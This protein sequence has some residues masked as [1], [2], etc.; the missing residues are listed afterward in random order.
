MLRTALGRSEWTRAAAEHGAR[1]ASLL[2]EGR[3]A[4]G[5][6]RA[7]HPIFNFL[8]SYYFVK[9]AADV[10]KKL[11]R[12]SPGALAWLRLGNIPDAEQDQTLSALRLERAP[13]D[14]PPPHDGRLQDSSSYCRVIVTQK[15]ADA[16]HFVQGVLQ[17]T[18]TNAPVLNCFGMH[19]WAMLYQE[20]DED[21]PFAAQFQSLPRRVAQQDINA[22]VRALKVNC[23]HFD[24]M[25]FFAK[26]AK[27]YSRHHDIDREQSFVSE[28]PACLHA[29]MDLLRHALKLGALIPGAMLANALELALEARALD[30]A[31]SPYDAT[32]FGLEPV[33]VETEV[34]KAEYK[35]RQ[36][37]LAQRA[38]PLRR[39]MLDYTRAVIDARVDPYASKEAASGAHA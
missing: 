7:D 24:A 12:W 28:N 37:R 6:L 22:T 17:S 18:T 2:A 30:V 3:D 26:S 8:R 32:A 23:T 35:T 4:K 31:A 38:R 39:A 15:D 25:R 13:Q 10:R 36:L 16:L 5:G 19:E 21:E 29:Q 9:S 27:T 20:A 14:E 34:G 1:V 11:T 33:A